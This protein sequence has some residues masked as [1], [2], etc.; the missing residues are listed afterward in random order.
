MGPV[1]HPGKLLS[2]QYAVNGGVPV[3]LNFRGYRRL[4]ADGHFNAD[5]PVASLEPGLNAIEVEGRFD[6]RVVARQVVTVTRLSG[7][8]PLPLAIDWSRA[9]DPQDVG[10][11]DAI[12]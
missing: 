5:I 2:L 11:S 7:S 4:A 10:Q 8:S 12:P 3:G 6:D 9:A 1:L